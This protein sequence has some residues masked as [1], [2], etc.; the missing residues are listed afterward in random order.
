VYRRFDRY[1]V[2]RFAVDG[3]MR[4][5]AF[6]WESEG[7]TLEKTLIELAKLKEAKRTKVCRQ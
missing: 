6:A 5:E 3:I 2:L 7:I 1:Y 4:Q